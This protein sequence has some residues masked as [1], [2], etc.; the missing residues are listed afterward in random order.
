[1]LLNDK[2]LKSLLRSHMHRASS[3]ITRIITDIRVVVLP[4][5]TLRVQNQNL[6]DPAT[7]NFIQFCKRRIAL[8]TARAIIQ[9][10]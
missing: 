2:E 3:S 8:H 9:I 10:V 5:N 7:I 6:S 1:M 4:N